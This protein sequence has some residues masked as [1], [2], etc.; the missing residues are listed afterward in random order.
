MDKMTMRKHLL[1]N[2]T[3]ML[4]WI[5][6]QFQEADCDVPFEYK[7]DYGFIYGHRCDFLRFWCCKKP[8]FDFHHYGSCQELKGGKL[9]DG[10][11]DYTQSYL[12]NPH[13]YIP[14]ENVEG[15]EKAMKE[16][17]RAKAAV[18]EHLEKV[19]NVSNFEV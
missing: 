5:S 11:R 19:R 8:S 12:T 7:F 4:N 15:F 13:W 17:P 14:H 2:V 16:W 10:D 6:E 18:L 9:Y 3:K 1:E